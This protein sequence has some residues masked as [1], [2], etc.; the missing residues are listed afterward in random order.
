[1]VPVIPFSS[2]RLVNPCVT[3]LVPF[4]NVRGKLVTIAVFVEGVEQGVDVDVAEGVEQF[5]CVL[6]LGQC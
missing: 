2:G 4:V 3:I 5:G 6:L 1:M